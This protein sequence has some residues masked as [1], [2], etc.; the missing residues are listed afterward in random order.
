[1]CQRQ[2]Q[3]AL[4]DASSAT[5]LDGLTRLTSALVDDYRQDTSQ[6]V[7]EASA[8]AEAEAAAGSD[9]GAESNGPIAERR[10]AAVGDANALQLLIFEVCA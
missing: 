10:E 1:M 9:A 3:R 6:T 5:A 7:D 4:E 2:K 8:P